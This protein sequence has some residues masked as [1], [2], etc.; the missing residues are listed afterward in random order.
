MIYEWARLVGHTALEIPNFTFT[1]FFACLSDLE[2][3]SGSFYLIPTHFC[4]V[5]STYSILTFLQKYIEL[6]IDLELGMTV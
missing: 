6:E 4:Y 5:A 2:E 1:Y 3:V